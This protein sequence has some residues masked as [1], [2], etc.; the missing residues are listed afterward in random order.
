MNKEAVPRAR[1]KVVAKKPSA[2][3]FDEAQAKAAAGDDDP[4]AVHDDQAA[5][6]D[7][8]ADQDEQDAD[9]DDQ[10]ADADHDD[11]DADHDDQEEQEEEEQEDEEED[12]EEE[13]CQQEAEGDDD[14]QGE[15]SS[16]D[17]YT[18]MRGP[19][20]GGLGAEMSHAH[21]WARRARR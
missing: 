18:N 16:E 4:D 19:D 5:D 8:H 17:S 11:Q 9:H 21:L 2:K 3:R 12:D 14:K 1:R 7:G 20:L 10:A 6:H 15:G 13:G